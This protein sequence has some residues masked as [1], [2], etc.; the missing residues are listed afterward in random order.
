MRLAVRR[1]YGSLLNSD[2]VAGAIDPVAW[3][4][5]DY[6]VA[7]AARLQGEDRGRRIDKLYRPGHTNDLSRGAADASCQRSRRA[8]RGDELPRSTIAGQKNRPRRRR[9]RGLLPRRSLAVGKQISFGDDV[10]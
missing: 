7:A 5:P 6:P 4:D 2:A 1:V 8:R 10:R 3:Q 9:R